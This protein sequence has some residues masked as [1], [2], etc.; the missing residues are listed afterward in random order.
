MRAL[1]LDPD[2]L[3]MDEPL[4]ALDPVTRVSLQR[5]LSA[6]FERLAKT[7]LIV[8]HDIAEA[9]ALAQ[10][11]VVMSAGVIVQRGTVE[12]MARAPADSFVAALLASRPHAPQGAA[13]NVTKVRGSA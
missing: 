3:L 8:T 5:E 2:V 13:S 10:Q 4:G 6:L 7:V 12:E 9:E 11:A 1:M